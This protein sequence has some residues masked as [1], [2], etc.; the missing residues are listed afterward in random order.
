MDF[1]I[2]GRLKRLPN[3]YPTYDFS[4]TVLIAIQHLLGTNGSLFE[5]L[6]QRGLPFEQMYL[7]G[8]VYSTNESVYREL[9]RRGA[10][11]HPASK[12]MG[13]VQLAVDYKLSLAKA[14][15]ETLTKAISKLASLQPPR[16]LLVVD[17]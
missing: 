13:E 16:T 3:Q 2:L 14:A 6:N 5:L 9:Q 10:F 1:P 15:G 11:V 8:K 12:S 4:N 7:L 17:D